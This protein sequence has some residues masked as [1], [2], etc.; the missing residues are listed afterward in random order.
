[1]NLPDK[2]F[3][4][5]MDDLGRAQLAFWTFYLLPDESI[6]LCWIAHRHTILFN[7]TPYNPDGD[8]FITDIIIRDISQIT[9]MIP[10]CA[11]ENH[12]ALPKMDDA[13]PGDQ[14]IIEVTRRGPKM[15]KPLKKTR[16]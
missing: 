14:I 10:V 7:I 2:L 4:T 3:V 15:L 8:L 16:G 13:D 11:F 6:R 12:F 5:F 9:S 1:M